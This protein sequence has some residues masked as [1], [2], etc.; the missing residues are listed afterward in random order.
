LHNKL[1]AT[2]LAL[3][4]RR[5]LGWLG[6]TAL[7]PL[8]D[9]FEARFKPTR[10]KAEAQSGFGDPTELIALF[11]AH[12]DALLA[13]VPAVPAAKMAE[14]APVVNPMFATVGEATLFMALHVSMHVGQLT[15]IRRSLGY[16]PLT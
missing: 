11:D 14:P 1:L 6:A 3:T 16:P 15:I 5:I 12:R 9:G 7:P 10:V 4:D 13:Q 8:P 2:A